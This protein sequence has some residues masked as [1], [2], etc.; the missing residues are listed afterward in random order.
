[1]GGS[2]TNVGYV[3]KAFPQLSETFIENERAVL[4][5]LGVT[6]D[7]FSLE[8]PTAAL[9]GP[10]GLDPS[11]LHYL[12][13]HVLQVA[14]LLRWTARRPRTMVANVWTALRCRSQTMFSGALAAGWIASGLERSGAVLVHAHF[15]SDAASAAIPAARLA[16]LPVTFTI[17]AR[18][19]YLRNR[20]LDVRIRA[21]D[22]VVTVCQYNV[23]QIRAHF[24]GLAAHP[25]DLVYC[26]VDPQAFPCRGEHRPG[27]HILSVGRLVEKKGFDLLVRAVGLLRDQGRHVTAEIIGQGPQMPELQRLVDDLGVAD[28]IS[29]AGARQP[30]EIAAHLGACDV[31]VLPCRIDD[32]GDR[33]SMPVVIKEAMATCLPVVAT[34]VVGIPEMVDGDVGRLVPPDDV[35]KLARAI[36]EILDLPG[37]ERRAL[38]RAGRKRV[39]DKFDLRSETLKLKAIF[40]QAVANHQTAR[41]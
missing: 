10:T 38:G 39:E 31:F 4:S 29:L 16:G 15:G 18:D 27:A 34:D 35:G 33:D 23:E 17:H 2:V 13:G 21:A 24:P 37:P 30:D 3:V 20:A 40:E 41:R 1:M 25:F 5:E 14:H 22:R 28:R 32:T 36:E 12:V 9:T 26:G 11:R 19:I 8:S 6:V 7:V